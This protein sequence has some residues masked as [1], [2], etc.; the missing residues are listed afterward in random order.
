MSAVGS[1][2]FDWSRAG[3]YAATA[4]AI[5][6]VPMPMPYDAVNRVVVLVVMAV[7]RLVVLDVLVGAA[8]HV[9]RPRVVEV[10]AAV[11]AVGRRRCD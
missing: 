1:R 3:L 11:S 5:A 6:F 7:M 10:G 4:I 9:A 8:V 2:P